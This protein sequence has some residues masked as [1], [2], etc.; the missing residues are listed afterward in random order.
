MIFSSF[1]PLF[2]TGTVRVIDNDT[3][4]AMIVGIVSLLFEFLYTL[5]ENSTVLINGF[6][7]SMNLEF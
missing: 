1:E 5:H 7:E 2:A 4:N 6:C 3:S